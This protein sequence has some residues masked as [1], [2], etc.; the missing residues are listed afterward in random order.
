ARNPLILRRFLPSAGMTAHGPL[1]TLRLQMH[2]S[3]KDFFFL[4]TAGNQNPSSQRNH[5][6]NTHPL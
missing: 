4:Y 6:K 3:A 2:I 1:T 5:V